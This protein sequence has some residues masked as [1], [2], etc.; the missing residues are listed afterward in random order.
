MTAEKRQVYYEVEA[1]IKTVSAQAIYRLIE[2]KGLNDEE[3][4]SLA[5]EFIVD[6][7]SFW[8]VY[9]DI[10]QNVQIP[11]NSNEGENGSENDGGG[12][13]SDDEG[14]NSGNTQNGND[15]GKNDQSEKGV[16]RSGKDFD[17]KWREISTKTQTEMETFSKESAEKA[18]EL[19]KYIA[20]ENRPRYNYREFLRKFF[21]RREVM[22]LDLDSYDY[23][24]YTYGLKVYGN[25]PLIESLE[26]KDDSKID[27]F[28][29][30]LDTS[31]SCSGD[32]IKGFLSE[33]YSILS[34]SESFFRKINLHII[35]C[36]SKVQSDT[37]I[38]CKEEFEKY[39]KSF[40]AR[41]FGG[42]DFRPAFEYVNSLMEE[43]KN[44]QLKGMIY[45]TDGY[46]QYPVKMPPYETAFVFLSQSYDDS[47]VPP[48]A[49]EII[50]DEEELLKNGGF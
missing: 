33:T 50:V 2:S 43:N 17:D 32:L 49:S 28:A 16:P 23:I 21:V 30:V 35:Q 11:D 42:T 19:I 26:Y 24:Y 10:K 18:G 40:E 29:I 1:N 8:V 45:F 36:D 9:D 4:K 48:W 39:V 22:R 14:E 6:D 37:V 46:G 44:F 47:G 31:A 20:F 7:H 34:D 3:I 12:E 13:E 25:M 15:S 41:G 27:E 5:A 38:T